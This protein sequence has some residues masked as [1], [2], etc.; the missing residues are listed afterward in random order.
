MADAAAD[1]SRTQRVTRVIVFSFPLVFLY[2]L[3]T[4]AGL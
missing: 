4:Q 2:G 3:P 1:Q